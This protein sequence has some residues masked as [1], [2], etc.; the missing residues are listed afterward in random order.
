MLGITV[1]D[2]IA[3]GTVLAA[4]IA[5]VLGLRNG[6]AARSAAPQQE[7]LLSIVG[8]GLID[9]AA[10]KDLAQAIRDMTA[11]LV[12]LAEDRKQQ[13]AEH[14]SDALKDIQDRLAEIDRLEQ[15]HP[16]RAP[17]RR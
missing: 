4:I 14:V 5:T 15:E 1:P 16:R 2:A 7:A 9:T 11:T 17:R 6:T 10:V 8:A 12:R 13:H 3:L